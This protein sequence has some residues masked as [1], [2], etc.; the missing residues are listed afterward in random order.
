MK[1]S[2][3][4]KRNFGIIYLIYYSLIVLIIKDGTAYYSHL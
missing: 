4:P 3:L 1:T 2:L